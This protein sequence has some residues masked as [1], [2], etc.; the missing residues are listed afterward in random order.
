MLRTIYNTRAQEVGF[1]DTEEKI[2][3][4]KRYAERGQIFL[5]KV[6][7]DG[8]KKERA[9]AI[10]KRILGQL[11]NMGCKKLIF[12]IIGIEEYA[13]SVWTTPTRILEVGVEINYDKRNKEGQNVTGFGKQLVISSVSDCRRF[14]VNQMELKENKEVRK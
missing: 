3:H 7:F 10:D 13:Y 8:E 5:R 9:I 14:E 4:T 6:M 2:Y 1:Y 11:I 12:T